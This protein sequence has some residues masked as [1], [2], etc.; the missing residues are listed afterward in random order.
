MDIYVGNLRYEV[1][2]P[3]LMK[4]MGEFGGVASVKLI[5]DRE[6]GRSKGFAFVEMEDDAEAREAIRTLNGRKYLGRP[7]AVREATP[8]GQQ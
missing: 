2:E 4:I 3:D 8:K 5:T 7:M 6:S 1:T